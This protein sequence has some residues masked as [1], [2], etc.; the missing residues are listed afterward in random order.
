MA[1][2][3]KN[4]RVRVG[5]QGNVGISD[6]KHV[7][8]MLIEESIERGAARASVE[9]EDDRIGSGLSLRGNKDVVVV[10]RGAWDIDIARPHRD[11]LTIL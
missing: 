10:L 5:D 7:R 4:V 6:S 2:P 3:T 11:E 1:G 9:P 8:A